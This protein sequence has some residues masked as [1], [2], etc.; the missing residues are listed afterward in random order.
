MANPTKSK[1][2]EDKLDV[3]MA[4]DPIV[5]ESSDEEPAQDPS[6]IMKLESADDADDE[7]D[8]EPEDEALDVAERDIVLD[9]DDRVP[10]RK[11]WP[12]LPVLPVAT[13]QD[14]PT[15]YFPSSGAHLKVISKLL[16]K[17]GV[18]VHKIEVA[19]RMHYGTHPGKSNAT[20]CI[21]SNQANNS[22]WDDAVRDIRAYLIE[23]EVQLC[24]EI[25]DHR[26]WNGMWSL[27]IVPTEKG[28]LRACKRK[29]HAMTEV[30][31]E[32]GEP[33]VS[34]DFYHRGLTHRRP[35][36]RPTAI[37]S[38]PYPNH[39]I[40]YSRILPAIKVIAGP[41]LEVEL[42]FSTVDGL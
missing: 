11:G 38:A 22:T 24:I 25:L 13:I 42:M 7:A 6:P 37:I 15:K 23:N 8:D 10:Y 36:C 5:I 31:K 4:S 16:E 34:L 19:H 1:E 2:G 3:T 40:W 28:V 12:L 14:V 27:P 41:K 29:R 18:E 17:S 20:L 26:L 30:L 32:S 21:L 9:V 39:A 33:W 35:D